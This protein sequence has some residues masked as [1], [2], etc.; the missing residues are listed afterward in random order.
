MKT[1]TRAELDEI[2]RKHKDWLCG[3]DGG[4]RADFRGANLCG[5]D[6][7]GADLRG[8]DFYRADLRGA[9]FC[10]A[11]LCGA[12][13]REANLY[14]AFLHGADIRGADLRGADIREV[15]YN[16]GTRFFALQCPEAGS[17]IGWK[18][19]DDYIVKLEICEDALR[20]SAT[21]R[22]CRCSKAK[23]LAIEELDGTTADIE[24]VRSN[25]DYDFIYKVGE[26]V[27]VKDFDTD[28]WRA[29]ATGIHFFITRGE[30]VN[31]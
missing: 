10:V 23:V 6:F 7:R 18:R 22:K 14:R 24:F 11:N 9:D 17:F 19:A 4:C 20:S 31:Y 29:C 3:Q 28:R 27:E 25:Y 12:N 8:A 16:E 30:A 2:L 26:I 15:G 13:L 1:Y 5:V 21:S